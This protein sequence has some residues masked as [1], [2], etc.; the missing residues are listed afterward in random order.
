MT[1]Q[2][3]SQKQQNRNWF[4]IPV[5]RA[6][7][8]NPIL[9]GAKH[10]LL[11]LEENRADFQQKTGS[12]GLIPKRSW[13]SLRKCWLLQIPTKFLGFCPSF[14]Y[15]FKTSMQ[16]CASKSGGCYFFVIMSYSFIFISRYLLLKTIKKLC[17][18]W[19]NET[20]NFVCC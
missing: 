1:T 18:I 13:K 2:N 8:I 11:S 7:T 10:T 16:H 17:F 9:R 12:L 15:V 19:Q 20:N 4:K 6:G 3:T 5:N 14:S